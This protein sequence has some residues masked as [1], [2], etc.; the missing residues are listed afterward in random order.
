M[1][2]NNSSTIAT[3]SNQQSLLSNIDT[4]SPKLIDVKEKVTDENSKTLTEDQVT[5]K[6]TRKGIMTDT[7]GRFELKGIESGVILVVSFKGYK[8]KKIKIA[9]SESV[10]IVLKNSNSQLKKV[11]VIAYGTTTQRMH[12]R[13]TITIQAEKI[14]KQ[15]V[16]NKLLALE[17]SVPGLLI[18]QNNGIPG[19]GVTVRIQGQNSISGD[20][21]TLY[22]IDRVKYRTRIVASAII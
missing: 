21:D 5:V 6:G 9:R 19:G 12:P 14:E 22:I 20:S 4:S 3:S 15:P 13:N 8:P 17:G 1:L 10:A 7:A 11:Q 18:T 16:E 2:Y